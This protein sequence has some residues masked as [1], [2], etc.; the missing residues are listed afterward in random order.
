MTKL[1]PGPRPLW[2]GFL[3]SARN[4]PDRPAIQVE[5]RE[6]TY[7]GLA[8]KALRLAATLQD[9][10]LGEESLTAVFAYRSETSFAAVL[11]ALLAGGGY[12]PLNRTFPV[13]RTR[14]ML[15]R[16]RCRALVV[17]KGSETQLDYLLMGIDYPLLINC[18]D[19]ADTT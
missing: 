8:E 14:L 17:D 9:V 11:G 4:F 5:G 12:V 10:N 7:H 13:D 19:R 16:S 1:D 6:V 18:P 3:D 2:T 15:T